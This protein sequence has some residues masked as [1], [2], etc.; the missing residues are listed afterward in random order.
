M[1]RALVGLVLAA[2]GCGG[3]KPAQSVT[4]VDRDGGDAAVATVRDAAP[5][6]PEGAAAPYLLAPVDRSGK[7]LGATSVAVKVE[8]PDPPAALVRSPGLDACRGERRAALRVGALNGVADVVVH[9]EPV[10]RGRAPD[11]PAT[12]ELQVADCRIEPAVA[13]ASRLGDEIAVTSVSERRQQVV[14]EYLGD[15]VEPVAEIELPLVGRRYRLV[16]D[17]PGRYRFVVADQ[18]AAASYVV[19]PGHPYYALTDATGKVR[20]A[21][22]PAGSYR[23]VAWHPPLPDG[24]EL[25]ASQS[26]AVVA[27]EPAEVTLSLAR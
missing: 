7:L 18:P 24:T 10:E 19:V 16:G 17:R 13:L 14:V 15:R 12:L 5:T 21:Q 6:T 23:V 20:F 25:S 11:P 1:P 8:W 22:V 27:G 4:R 26:I 3:G 9:L 2:I